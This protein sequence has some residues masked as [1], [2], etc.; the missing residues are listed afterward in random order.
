MATALFIGGFISLGIVIIIQS[1]WKQEMAELMQKI[2]Y[3]NKNLN[4]ENLT[5][6]AVTRSF[7][8]KDTFNFSTPKVIYD[9]RNMKNPF[10]RHA[11]EDYES[12]KRKAFI[13]T[14]IF[15]CLSIIFGSLLAI[16]YPEFIMEMI[17]NDG[18]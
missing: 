17:N 18:P 12:G 16:L 1:N 8:I 5:T 6:F 9:D 11:I 10:Y 13:L 14:T 15:M 4:E 2:D 7:D 3:L